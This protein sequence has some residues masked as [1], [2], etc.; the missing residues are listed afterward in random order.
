MAA[1]RQVFRIELM[2][3]G[4]VPGAVAGTFIGLITVLLSWW[5]LGD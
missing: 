2:H 5:V 3:P 1:R 4:I